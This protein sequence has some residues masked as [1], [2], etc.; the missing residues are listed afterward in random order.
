MVSRYSKRRARQRKREIAQ[1]F[2]DAGVPVTGPI[3]QNNSELLF[4]QFRKDSSKFGSVVKIL[5]ADKHNSLARLVLKYLTNP[6]V[7]VWFHDYLTTYLEK[8]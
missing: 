1:L 6:C 4:K 3:I 7:Q 5:I 8:R 2:S